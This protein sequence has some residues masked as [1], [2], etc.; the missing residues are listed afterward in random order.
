[1]I[2]PDPP[3]PSETV[4]HLLALTDDLF[5]IPRL[6]DAARAA[7]FELRVIARPEELG[8]G[9][10]PSPRSVPLT[11]PLEGPD[12]ALVRSLIADRPAL[13]LVDLASRAI[14]WAHWISVLKSGAATRRIPILAFGPHV[15]EASLDE[16]QRSGAD[17]ALSRGAFL[18]NL[19][20]WFTEYAAH[21]DLAA[22]K[23]ACRAPLSDL[24]RRGLTLLNEGQFFEAHEV[25]EHAWME[26]GDPAGQLYR[27]LLQ[28]A[29]ACHHLHKENRRGAAKMLLRVRPWIDPLPDECRG[30]DV[31][32]V[33]RV[34][35]GLQDSLDR[36][37]PG[38]PTSA[39][40]PA[41]PVVPVPDPPA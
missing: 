34:V 6:E 29:V 30:V 3:A 11:E 26:A 20:G 12:A 28:L 13:I 9:G 23:E 8:A 31:A 7:G 1:M 21:P 32:A 2:G 38:S 4:R 18:S 27:V 17:R 16:A 37:P 41:L 5:V 10:P 35:A 24:G 22:L 14:P 15:D 33:R 40:V 39:L 19:P 25:L 36:L